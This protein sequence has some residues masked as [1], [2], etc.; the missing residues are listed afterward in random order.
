MDTPDG[1]SVSTDDVWLAGDSDAERK[2]LRGYAELAVRAGANVQAGQFCV[3]TSQVEDL[4][5]ARM[6]AEA[7]WR[8]GACDV[9]TFFFDR[10]DRYL[11]ARYGADER[12]GRSEVAA[13][14]LFEWLLQ[15]RA[16]W[17]NVARDDVPA[18]F[19]PLDQHRLAEVVPR[20]RRQLYNELIS[21]Q[22]I[23]WTIAAPPGPQW[24]E[25][26]FGSP[27]VARLCGVLDG[28]CR[29]DQPDPVAAWH[30]RSRE[31]EARAALLDEHR[32]DALHLRGPGTDLTVGLLDG[33]H[34]SSATSTTSWGQVF[35][36]NLPTEEVFATPDWRRTEGRVAAARPLA[37]QSGTALVEGM[38][39]DFHNG[40]VVAAH[41]DLGEEF[42]RQL[43]ATDDGARRL[44]ELALVTDSP[45]TATGIPCFH[46][47]LLDENAGSHLALGS[48]YT[49][50]VEATV[51]LTPDQLSSRG[52]N[53]SAIH[54]DVV[55]G[56]SYTEVDG[57][58]TD[59]TRV[60]ILAGD[61]WLLT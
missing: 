57:I 32:F 58:H 31:L 15:R 19:R 8:A 4:P 40:R 61:N 30:A 52:V 22:R 21:Q 23:A 18:F 17:V 53:Q 20:R 14:G 54:E 48:A 34:W 1:A 6:V 33:A 42:L 46:Q 25:A 2:F 41:A 12:L 10:F 50:L 44:G 59:R 43:L 16:A 29:L 55:F 5:F 49:D 9:Q 47:L 26:V 27:D 24:A 7:A 3:I 56:D 51:G 45:I 60:P 37:A 38:R 39:L 35:I 28:I 13:V 11:L 36:P